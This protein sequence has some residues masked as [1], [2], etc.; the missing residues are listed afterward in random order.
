MKSYEIPPNKPTTAGKYGQGR[1][2]SYIVPQSRLTMFS[3]RT[4]QVYDPKGY[5]PSYHEW[6]PS[7]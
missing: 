5:K 1:R 3:N 7:K 2:K 6:T 4:D